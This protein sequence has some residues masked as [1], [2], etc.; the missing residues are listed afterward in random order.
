MAQTRDGAIKVA[1]KKAGVCAEEYRRLMQEGMKWCTLCK[2]WH[3]RSEFA[4][5]RSRWDG[6]TA[7]CRFA[8]N[9]LAQAQYVPKPKRVIKGRSFVPARDGD[10]HQARRRVNYFVE[11]GIIPH[12]NALPCAACGHVWKEGERRHEYDHHL[13][14]AAEHHECVE[15][16]CTRCHAQR[17]VLRKKTANTTLIEVDDDQYS[18]GTQRR[19]DPG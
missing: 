5:D 11:A 1:A 2:A 7:G 14:Y 3:P 19:R 8:R 4:S 12:P 16:V 10:V 6:L 9:A 13:G 18:V 17:E 15:P